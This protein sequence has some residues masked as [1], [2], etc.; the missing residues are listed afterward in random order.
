MVEVGLG[1]ECCEDRVRKKSPEGL[2]GI[3]VLRWKNRVPDQN[4]VPAD[5]A[6]L[7]SIN[8]GTHRSI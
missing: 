2:P 1:P 3:H 4:T 8:L 7:F 6:I 5:I